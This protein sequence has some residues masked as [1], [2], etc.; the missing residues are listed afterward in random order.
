MAN[1][2]EKN[3]QKGDIQDILGDLDSLLKRY[4]DRYGSKDG[5]PHGKNR[6]DGEHGK[7]NRDGEH[8]K[9]HRD[10]DGGK[11]QA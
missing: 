11:G 4:R 2:K 3:D 5:D 10:G 7:R 8:G 6:R 9:R 1:D